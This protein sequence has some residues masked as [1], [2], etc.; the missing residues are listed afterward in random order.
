MFDK[1][2]EFDSYLEINRTADQEKK[3]GDIESLKALAEENGLDPDDTQDYI[4][5]LCDDL[6]TANSAAEGKIRIELA[7]LKIK[8]GTILDDYAK[9]TIECSIKNR[10]FAIA[11]RKKGKTLKGYLASLID[12]S[13][14]YSY[15]VPDEIVKETKEAKK[16][17]GSHELRLG[18]ASRKDRLHLMQQYYGVRP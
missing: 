2:G 3:E 14:K 11:V 18:D 13:C 1:F 4:E 5:G 10:D 8:D 15:V 9:E 12:Y 17:L 7:A 6:C 16:R